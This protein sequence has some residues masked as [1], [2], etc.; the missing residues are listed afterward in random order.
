MYQSND[1]GKVSLF[2]TILMMLLFMVP[3]YFAIKATIEKEL[4]INKLA[5]MD[6]TN[7]IEKSIQANNNELPRSV[8][9]QFALY[10]QNHNI[11]VSYLKKKPPNFFFETFSEHPYLYYQKNIDNNAY[12]VAFITT[13]MRV[14][15]SNIFMMATLLFLI[16]LIVVYLLN[17][18]IIRDT[19]VPYRI[20]QKY[21][22]DFFNDAMHELK[23]PLSVINVNIE[24]MDQLGQKSKHLNRMQAATK[25]MQVT[26][27]DVEYHIKHKNI[28][29]SKEQINISEF[30]KTRIAFFEDIALTK[31]IKIEQKIQKNLKV[32][33][34]KTELQ[35]LIDN[36]L[37]NA[38]KYSHFQ[39][40]I[41]LELFDDEEG[42][43]Y[44]KIKDYGVGIKDTKSIF[45]R[46]KRENHIQG[47]F[48]LGLN[49]VQ[50]ICLKN[51]IKIK[52]ESKDTLG[53]TF[54]YEILLDKEKFLDK[55]ENGNK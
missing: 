15:H 46:F 54:M 30:L 3:S 32:F 27:E 40:E 49:I 53:S 42:K 21:M 51:N 50:N 36:T 18:I 33:M 17:R 55:V 39:G 26:Y 25:Q 43:C 34:N 1:E 20:M 41:E 14:N 52:I 16:I 4:F 44:L 7:E 10:D 45:D 6:W 47:G 13:A 31:A 9:F 22:D 24:L 37:S 35:R 48:G 8:K 19:A 11:I 2:Y 38:I 23:T 29:Y 12:S 28:K 5:L